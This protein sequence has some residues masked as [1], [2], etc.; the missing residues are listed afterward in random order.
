MQVTKGYSNW[1]D[2]TVAFNKHEGSNC[3]RE[4]VE[5]IVTLPATTMHIGVQLSQEYAREMENNRKMLLNVLS[6]IQ[7]LA[8]KACHLEGVVMR[9]METFFSY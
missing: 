5:V 9:V 2:A 3:H 8:D 6:C 1:K 7:F 4:A